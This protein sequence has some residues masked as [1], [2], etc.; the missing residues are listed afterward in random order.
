MVRAATGSPGSS[1]STHC[2]LLSTES[3]NC[4]LLLPSHDCDGIIVIIII[5]MAGRRSKGSGKDD[6]LDDLLHNHGGVTTDDNQERVPLNL[7]DLSRG[8]LDV[9]V[10][11]SSRS[12]PSFC[13]NLMSLCC[14]YV[15]YIFDFAPRL[16]WCIGIVLLIVPSYLIVAAILNPVEHFGVISNDYSEI[17]S[18]HDFSLGKI[19]HWCLKGDNDSCRC[20]D[21]LQPESRGEYKAWAS[22]HVFNKKTVETLIEQG[23]AEP[24]IAFLG[25]S[26]VEEMD[27]HW[28]GDVRD[29]SLE[30]LE[31]LFKKHFQRYQPDGLNKKA[32]DAVAL[33]IAGDTVRAP[34]PRPSFFFG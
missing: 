11:K 21:P 18:E 8:Q 7:D 29:K 6:D 27:G 25:A 32:L 22:A 14:A 1:I 28:F 20:G 13:S 30:D 19:D 31:I 16:C 15:M 2:A 3:D 10:K 5:I 12:A 34:P 17:T 33:G 24:D 9:P 26:I 4:A 23:Q